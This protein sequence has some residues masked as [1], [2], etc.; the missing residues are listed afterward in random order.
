[1]AIIVEEGPVICYEN[2]TSNFGK[3]TLLHM[4]DPLVKKYVH[5]QKSK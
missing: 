5:I 1:M 3:L 4:T 2:M